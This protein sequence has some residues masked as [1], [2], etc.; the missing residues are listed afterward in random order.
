MKILIKLNDPINLSS[1][2]LFKWFYTT[3]D[4]DL[5]KKKCL[6]DLIS[7]Y[8]FSRFFST[9]KHVHT[10]HIINKY[11]SEWIEWFM[12][13]AWWGKKYVT[14]MKNGARHTLKI[15]IYTYEV[16]IKYLRKKMMINDERS[17][18]DN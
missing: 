15:C 10:I 18:F 1:F 12:N 11:N 17:N 7:W 8:S 2:F 13:N 3:N 9:L 6:A 14:C 4:I 5:K 16:C